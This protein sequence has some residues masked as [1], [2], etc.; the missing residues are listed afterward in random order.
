MTDTLSGNLRYNLKFSKGLPAILK[1]KEKK[2]HSLLIAIFQSSKRSAFDWPLIYSF[3][4][5]IQVIYLELQMFGLS[6]KAR[7]ANYSFELNPHSLLIANGGKSVVILT[8]NEPVRIF[9]I[10]SDF[11][12]E[13]TLA[14][15]A[16][17]RHDLLS[18]RGE[19]C[20]YWTETTG[21]ML[22]FWRTP[23]H[24]D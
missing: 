23:F 19:S 22:F 4:S 7:L 1:V 10:V 12:R 18:A 16:G 20:R 5:F 9:E 15:R 14:S 13:R 6:D 11:T 3:V 21:K 24:K 17:P 2:M 8:H